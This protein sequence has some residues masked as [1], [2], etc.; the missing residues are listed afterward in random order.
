MK[1]LLLKLASLTAAAVLLQAQTPAPQTDSKERPARLAV[2][3]EPIR[4]IV[5]A[6]RSHAIVALGNVEFRGNEQ[7]HMFQV[8][9]IRD[10]G[11]QA[12]VNDIVVEFGNARYQ[13]V[14]DRFVRGENVAY[15]SLR[16]LNMS[17]TC[18]STR[19][20]SGLCAR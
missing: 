17:G 11:F 10:P 1:N 14:V 4:A 6:F 5:E 20:S 9:L 15:E 2:P 3:V 8:S 16:R 18:R 19:T 7:S 13:E 12:A